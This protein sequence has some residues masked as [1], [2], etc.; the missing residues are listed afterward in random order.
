MNVPWRPA[1]LLLLAACSRP[2]EGHQLGGPLEEAVHDVVASEGLLLICGHRNGE[3]L[4]ASPPP[5]G[6]ADAFI[7]A[8]RLDGTRL[9]ERTW[10]TGGADTLD[11]MVVRGD[12]IYAVGRTS[13]AFEGFVN[14]GG[15]DAFVVE[16]PLSGV[17][18]HRLLQFG[19]GAG[20]RPTRLE[21]D[22][23]GALL[24]AGY[25]WGASGSER[26]FMARVT[27]DGPEL[28]TAWVR[29]GST[30]G[31]ILQG[32]AATQV[33]GEMV[34][35]GGIRTG[36]QAGPFVRRVAP[37]GDVLWNR[38]IGS[39]GGDLVTA[40]ELGPDG[41]VWA[42]GVTSSQLGA[43][44]FGGQDAFVVV[45]DLATGN[46]LR[47]MQAGSP[48]ADW[49][50]DLVLSRDGRAFVAGG[51]HGALPGF[52]PRGDRDLFALRFEPDGRWSGVWQGGSTAFDDA[53][54]LT[55]GRDGRLYL[56]GFTQG[57]VAPGASSDGRGDGFVLPAALRGR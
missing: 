27:T 45:L 57:R 41:N 34:V 29:N 40:V 55:L 11:A 4:P 51:T 5:G 20:E 24:I 56:A 19:A 7:A 15:V 32:M 26:T 17:G 44:A 22:A 31:E 10:A 38:R 54:A 35:G 1:L 21:L 43:E 46:Q 37:N 50:S 33:A 30:P 16:L 25:L 6:D 8:F 2:W 28:R 48:D 13:G 42:A 23:G 14:A 3:P 36:P 53:L 39:S 18:T 47:V 12:R 9:W 52:S 49:P